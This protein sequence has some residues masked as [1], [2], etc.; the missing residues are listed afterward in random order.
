LKD[1]LLKLF[2]N[3]PTLA[4]KD[5]EF[6]DTLA[7]DV[8]AVIIRALGLAPTNDDQ[9]EHDVDD[10]YVSQLGVQLCNLLFYQRGIT[11]SEQKSIAKAM[12][13]TL[14]LEYGQGD[15]LKTRL[16]ALAAVN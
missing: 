8:Q 11:G 5:A 4:S 3:N 2:A 7:E 13:Q 10:M 12:L 9:L 15:I 14:A 6:L 1:G 16:R